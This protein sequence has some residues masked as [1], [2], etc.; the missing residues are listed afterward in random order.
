M[1]KK[2]TLNVKEAATV[3]GVSKSLLYELIAKGESGLPVLRIRNRI[4]IPKK[5]LEEF[6]NNNTEIG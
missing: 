3:L 4:L 6:V 1:D 5:A 2:L